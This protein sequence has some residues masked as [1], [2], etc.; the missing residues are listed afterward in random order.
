MKLKRTRKDIV[1]AIKT[2]P[3]TK[4]NEMFEVETKVQAVASPSFVD[5]LE[6][7]A[8]NR[9]LVKDRM[10]EKEKERKEFEKQTVERTA[11]ATPKTDDMRKMKMVEEFITTTSKGTFSTNENVI[12]VLTKSR[13]EITKLIENARKQD[14]KYTISRIN[15]NFEFKYIFEKIDL[16]EDLEESKENKNMKLK[17][18][19]GDMASASMSDGTQVMANGTTRHTRNYNYEDV[20]FR[21]KK[22]IGKGTSRYSNRPWQRF[23][24]ANALRDAMIDANIDKEFVKKCID[25]THSLESAIEYFAKNYSESADVL[26]S[27]KLKESK[28]LKEEPVT[29]LEPVHDSRKSF[30]GKAKVDEREDGSLV[31]YSYGTPV[32][33][34]KND[35]AYLLSRVNNYSGYSTSQ[36]TI[37]HVKDFLKQ[38]GFKAE[39]L[40]QLEKDYKILHSLDIN[41]ESKKVEE[42]FEDEFSSEFKIQYWLTEEDREEGFSD[43]FIDVFETLEEAIAVAKKMIDRGDVASVEVLNEHDEMVWGYDGI[44]TWGPEK[45]ADD[46]DLRKY[47]EITSEKL[48]SLGRTMKLKDALDLWW[49]SV[50]IGKHILYKIFDESGYELDG[51]S[52][53]SL[54][55]LITLDDGYDE[56]G[57][58]FPIV[59]AE[60]AKEKE[61]IEK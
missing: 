23:D 59:R 24:F 57:D 55:R 26:E 53:K 4:R 49:N 38:H 61:F 58:G 32:A 9:Q 50:R 37:R 6:M 54:N 39:S 60:F 35:Q 17:E 27:K 33:M 22:G 43:I 42:D 18:S 30:Y 21:W 20:T 10:K 8:K 11:N 16:K 34:I 14:I 41:E 48:K 5:A 13:P 19:Y 12:T 1:E 44:G 7:S 52:E 25:E 3:R 28:T 2:Y 29:K 15:E 47:K 40:K 56:D 46:E 45:D 51:L 36:T 31:L